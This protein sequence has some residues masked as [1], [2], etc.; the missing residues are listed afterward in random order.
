MSATSGKTTFIDLTGRQFGR[1]TVIAKSSRPRRWLCRCACGTQREVCGGT[2]REG[3]STRCMGCRKNVP[4]Q[5]ILSGIDP[6]AGAM[7]LRRAEAEASAALLQMQLMDAWKAGK[8]IIEIEGRPAALLFLRGG[9][10]VAIIDVE[11]AG[12]LRLGN[13]YLRRGS[14]RVPY[15]GARVPA[16]DGE[17]VLLHRVVLGL[18]EPTPTTLVD[19]ISGNTL[20]NRRCNLR[21]CTQSQNN[22]NVF[23]RARNATGFKG[24]RIVDGRFDV[25]ISVGSQTRRVGRFTTL[26]DA[27]LAYD[28]AA[29]SAFGEFAK[30]NFPEAHHG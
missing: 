10:G 30:L 20:D 26:R 7:A 3:T 11:S 22:A 18:G 19:H 17:T 29:L 13:W 2:L 5:E 25:Q 24:V 23:T 14:N 27:A 16:S 9:S 6:L 12:L 15:V 28:Q 8:Q 21:L 1:W 4:A